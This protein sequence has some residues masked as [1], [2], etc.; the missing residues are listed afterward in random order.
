MASSPNKKFVQAQGSKNNSQTKALITN[1][2]AEQMGTIAQM[3][4]N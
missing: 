3:A 4:G 1:I 2:D